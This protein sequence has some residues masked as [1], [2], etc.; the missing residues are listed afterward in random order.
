MSLFSILNTSRL[1]L[2]ANQARLQVVGN[3]IANVNTEGYSRQRGHLSSIAEGG[4]S[5]DRIERMRDQFLAVQ[6][7]NSRT[8]LGSSNALS[9]NLQQVESVLGDGTDNG[10]TRTIQ[11]FFNSLQDFSAMPDGLTEREAVRSGGR[12][13]ASRFSS[14]GMNLRQTRSQIDAQVRQEVDQ[15]NN[16]IS[17]IA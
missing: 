15:V 2:Y 12:Q 11:Y 7:R 5:V 6:F 13:M 17:Q 4:V 16:I 10:L 14:M 1:G 3:N 8:S 9:L